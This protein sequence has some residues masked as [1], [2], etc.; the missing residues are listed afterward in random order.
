MMRLA[1][2]GCA[3]AALLWI[4]AGSA[5]AQFYPRGGAG[6]TNPYGRPQ[7]SPYL[8]LL[9]GGDPAANYYAGVLPEIQRRSL[10][11]QFGAAINDIDRRFYAQQPG[12]ELG[13]V[14]TTTGHA[15]AFMNT[16]SYFS[17]P[18]MQR[19]GSVATGGGRK[20]R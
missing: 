11:A 6:Y 19:V 9:R 15:T 16:S 3:A 17:G 18:S 10:N 14:T 5:Q 12:D 2:A 13:E 8:N 7:L 1:L 4:S 20:G